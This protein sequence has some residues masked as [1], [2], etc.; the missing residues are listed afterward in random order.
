[1]NKIV[2]KN[3][4]IIIFGGFIL[5]AIGFYNG[6]PLLAPDSFEYIN[7]GFGKYVKHRPILY[8]L[9]VRHISLAFSLWLVIFVQSFILSY[10]I[11]LFI[12]KFSNIKLNTYYKI[13]I[14]IL[15]VTFSG[16]SWYV[17]QIMPDI[18]SAIALLIVILLLQK[19]INKKVNLIFL[20]IILVFSISSHNSNLLFFT[21]GILLIGI[22]ALI[23]KKL[24]KEFFILKQY[25]L[26]LAIIV[27]SWFITPLIN[28]TVV[29]EDFKHKNKYVFFAA[30]MIESGMLKTVL[31]D[32]CNKYDWK[33][34]KYKDELPPHKG[35]FLWRETSP[36]KKI[37]GW[38]KSEKELKKI[39]LVSFSKPKYCFYNTFYLIKNTIR[40]FYTIRI[41]RLMYSFQSDE[42][43]NKVIKTY[44]STDYV[45]F[46]ASKQN[47]SKI[48]FR[49][50]TKRQLAFIIL[51]L[52][53]IITFM[54]KFYENLKDKKLLFFTLYFFIINAATVSFFGGVSSRY[55]GKIVWIFPLVAILFIINN[56]KLWI[57]MFKR[58]EL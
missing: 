49:Y 5:I 31:D 39:V 8:S 36:L 15:L 41:G 45:N 2:N 16:V 38:K 4:F 18:F 30:T 52:I 3:W 43:K 7:T 14:Y 26:I 17:S 28:K 53:I 35:K 55:Q 25:F 22:F 10:I 12:E 1:M 46:Y 48:K 44:F 21:T 32:N 51:F 33:L 56:Y 11:N 27:L 23:S 40:Q 13:L 34:C 9:F 20:S 58:K 54:G 37:G 29:K 42:N 24:K 19:K 50:A 6:F 57:K 47:Y